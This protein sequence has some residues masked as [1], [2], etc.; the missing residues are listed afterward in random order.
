LLL[1]TSALATAPTL[2]VAAKPTQAELEQV[3]RRIDALREELNTTENTR[4]DVRAQLSGI[5]R[6][7]ATTTTQMRSTGRERDDNQKR[8]TELLEQKK[9]L[10][11]EL[12][13]H[14][15][16][17]A[18]QLR[19]AY[20]AGRQDY[21]KMLLN[22]EQPATVGRMLVYYRYFDA[23]R[24]DQI[25]QVNNRIERLGAVED[26]IA[27]K[28][29]NLATLSERL[30]RDQT[31]LL[32]MQGDR[33]GVLNRIER[34]VQDKSQRLARLRDDERRLADLVERLQREFAD[35][36]PDIDQRARFA[37][38]RG[39][40]NW[41][42]AGQVLVPF[43]AARGV[44][45]LQWQGVVLGASED[46]EVRS[47]WHGRVAFADW[48]HGYGMV[49]IIDHGDGYL[50]LYAHNQS[51]AKEVGDW[52]EAGEVIATV[53]NSGGQK[54]SGLYFEIRHNGRPDNPTRWLKTSP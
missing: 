2:S 36:P 20:S 33:R 6:K 9:Q 45:Q 28:N 53:G 3:R 44:G 12:A 11:D 1:I 50:T 37:G 24:R 49:M 40:L 38:L 19:T 15:A 47:V 42:L 4:R 30:Q 5:E 17:L 34:E 26:A 10:Q 23:A 31:A 46:S 14:R 35:I 39:K 54:I 22:Q 8:L 18:H 32:A 7:I 51:L 13:D 48:L 21:F 25:A 29:H 43:G 52:A 27:A 16:L 41:P